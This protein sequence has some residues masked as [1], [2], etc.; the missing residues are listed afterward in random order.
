MA[1]D[2]HDAGERAEQHVA[3]EGGGELGGDRRPDARLP[4]PVLRERPVGDRAPLG[5][6]GAPAGEGHEGHVI[7]PSRDHAAR[8]GGRRHQVGEGQHRR[9]AGGRQQVR[10][11]RRPVDEEGVDVHVEDVGELPGGV[12]GP[13]PHDTAAQQVRGNLRRE[14]LRGDGQADGK[15]PTGPEPGGA[16]RGGRPRDE[17]QELGSRHDPL[18]VFEGRVARRLAQRL[19]QGRRKQAASNRHVVQHEVRGIHPEGSPA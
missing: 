19:E 9:A 5:I 7:G 16:Q 17:A 18:P 15:A 12:A 1:Y 4:G 13:Y 14:G 8:L 3:R 2:H 11:R 6:P 10:G